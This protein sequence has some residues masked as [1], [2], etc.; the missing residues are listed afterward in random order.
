MYIKHNR[1][2]IR[3][4]VP[5]SCIFKKI[6][7]KSNLILHKTATNTSR[8]TCIY[9]NLVV[10]RRFTQIISDSPILK[11]RSWVPGRVDT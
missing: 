5:S 6:V 11:S 2:M 7:N 9:T 1:E 4:T 10:I 8:P 3:S